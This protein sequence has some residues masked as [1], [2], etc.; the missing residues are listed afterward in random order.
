MDLQRAKDIIGISNE[1]LT[2]ELVNRLYKKLTLIHHP[3]KSGNE[4]TFK[5]LLNAHDFLIKYIQKDKTVIPQT[6]SVPVSKFVPAQSM[7]T[8]NLHKEL[9]K[10]MK[11]FLGCKYP[12][13]TKDSTIGN[14][15]DDHLTCR[16][17]SDQRCS[18]Q[19][20]NKDGTKRNCKRNAQ[21]GRNYCISHGKI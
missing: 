20:T 8:T 19:I 16:K 11:T 15:C 4:E 14:Y 3:D 13:C 17:T 1:I 2:E 5:R 6:V 9:K 10:V 21:I 18:F 12:G 7:N